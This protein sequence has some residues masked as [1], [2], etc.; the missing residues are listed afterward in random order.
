MGLIF[1]KNQMMHTLLFSAQDNDYGICG[2]YN[3]STE[4]PF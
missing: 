3:Q 1:Q 4:N 2:Y